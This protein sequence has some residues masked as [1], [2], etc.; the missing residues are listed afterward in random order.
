MG[1][2]DIQNIQNQWVLVLNPT[3]ALGQA[4]GPKHITEAP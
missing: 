1:K 3:D 2:L 4:L